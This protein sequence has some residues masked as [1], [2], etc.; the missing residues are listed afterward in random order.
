MSLSGVALLTSIIVSATASNTPSAEPKWAGEYADK[1]FLDGQ[2]GFQMSIEESGMPYRSPSMPLTMMHTVQRPTARARE[3][4]PPKT[5]WSSSGKI[6]SRIPELAG[7]HAQ[8]R[9]SS[10]R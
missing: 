8:A 3:E 4:S 7:L 1:K 10:C 2:A 6:V 5:R 9:T